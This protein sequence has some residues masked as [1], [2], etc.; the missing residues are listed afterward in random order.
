[1]AWKEGR[2]AEC[3]TSYADSH[4]MAHNHLRWRDC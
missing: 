4:L 2:R 3:D 1:V